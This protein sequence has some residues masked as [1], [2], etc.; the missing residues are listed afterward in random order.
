[1]DCFFTGEKNVPGEI[2]GSFGGGVTDLKD[3][4]VFEAFCL[5]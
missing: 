5:L 4:K 1:L 2:D 3:F